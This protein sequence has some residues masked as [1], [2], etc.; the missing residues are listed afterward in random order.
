M[1]K[2]VTPL[3][4]DSIILPSHARVWASCTCGAVDLVGKGK[5]QV[6]QVICAR[7]PENNLSRLKCHSATRKYSGCLFKYARRV[8]YIVSV[9]DPSHKR[10]HSPNRRETHL[11]FGRSADRSGRNV[12][13]C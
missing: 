3:N 8:M 9:E 4:G 11:R 1:T 12:A 2:S 5:V 7:P 13:T 10:S 6:T